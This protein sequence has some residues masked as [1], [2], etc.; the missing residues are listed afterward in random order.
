M[1]ESTPF[2]PKTNINNMVE[3]RIKNIWGLKNS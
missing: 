3:S 2:K 1:L